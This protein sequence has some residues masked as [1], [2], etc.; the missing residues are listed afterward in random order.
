MQQVAA[1]ENLEEPAHLSRYLREPG[2]QLGEAQVGL[3]VPM[4]LSCL[5]AGLFFRSESVLAS[6][7]GPASSSAAQL[8]VDQERAAGS[9]VGL[10]NSR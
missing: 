3:E 2:T 4:D 7:V 9:V 6:E 8:V 5:L 1:F 10:T